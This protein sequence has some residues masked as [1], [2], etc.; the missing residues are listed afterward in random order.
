[1]SLGT[2]F[3]GIP[4]P[5]TV[6]SRYLE[7]VG[8]IF[9]KFKL[10]EVQINLHFG[11][12]GLVKKSPTPNYGWGKPLKCFFIQIDAS[13]FAEF[14]ISEFEIARVDCTSTI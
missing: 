1:M 10:P 7:V 8:T 3:G 4:I 11:Y 9:H 13:S 2:D 6:N 12:F 5:N 14:E